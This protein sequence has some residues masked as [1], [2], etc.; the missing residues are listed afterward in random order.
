MLLLRQ[1]GHSPPRATTMASLHIWSFRGL[2]QA[3]SAAKSHGRVRRPPGRF[4]F[5]HL[6]R[7]FDG[8]WDAKTLCFLE[9]AEGHGSCRRAASLVGFP[10]PAPAM[11]PCPTAPLLRVG[12]CHLISNNGDC[13]WLARDSRPWHQH[14]GAGTHSDRRSTRDETKVFERWEPRKN[15]TAITQS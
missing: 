4:S 1:A 10:A 7:C 11:R 13:A 12:Q 2:R 15:P 3:A 9:G 5:H 6:R 8:L 14:H